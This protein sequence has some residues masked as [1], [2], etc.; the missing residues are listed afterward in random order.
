MGEIALIAL[1]VAGTA[2]SVVQQQKAGSANRRAQAAA[3]K[4][5][6][7]Q[8]ARERRRVFREGQQ[9]RANIVASASAQGAT[10]SSASTGGQAGVQQQASSSLQF[11]NLTEDLSIER[12]NALS[13]VSRARGLA[14]IGSAVSGVAGSALSQFDFS[15]APVNRAASQVNTSPSIHSPFRGN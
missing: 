3:R 9:Q 5:Q 2:F 11:I 6:A 8:A 10:G 13:D 7:L 4:R 14:G 1:A 15:G 12:A